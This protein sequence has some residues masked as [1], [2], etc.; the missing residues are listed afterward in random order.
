MNIVEKLLNNLVDN[1][2]PTLFDVM[3]FYGESEV[4]LIILSTEKMSMKEA[5]K[6]HGINPENYRSNYNSNIF[7]DEEKR[8]VV[9]HLKKGIIIYA[10]DSQSEKNKIEII[11]NTYMDGINEEEDNACCDIKSIYNY[12]NVEKLCKEYFDL[13]D[14]KFIFYQREFLKELSLAIIM[15]IEELRNEIRDIEKNIFLYNKELYVHRKNILTE[16]I[17]GKCENKTIV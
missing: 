16:R 10:I 17:F 14:G 3:N 12:N 15:K 5:I 9:E 11:K 6:K 1:L 13:T 2:F 4:D 8:S 7:Y